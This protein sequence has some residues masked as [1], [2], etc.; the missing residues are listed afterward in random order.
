MP[1]VGIFVRERLT[2][3]DAEVVGPRSYKGRMVIRYLRLTFEALT[4]RGHFIGVEAHVLFPAG[5]IGLVA[6]RMRGIP[7]VV[8]AHGAD[9]R[10]TANENRLYRA[11]AS[12]VA[13]HADAVV[14]NSS[15][16]AEMIRSLGRDPIVNPPGI[17]LARF[18]PSPRPP[19]R[20]VLYLG[21]NRTEK[22]YDRAVG[23]ADTLAGQRLREVEP[24]EVPRLIAE[25]DI[26]LMP[27]RA[28]PY[29]L[30][31][32]EAIA[33]GRWVVAANVDGL[34]EIVTDGLNGTLVDGDEFAEAVQQVPDY[35]PEHLAATAERFSLQRHQTG[36]AR[37]WNDVVANRVAS[38]M[39]ST[40]EAVDTYGYW[41]RRLAQPG[42]TSVGRLGASARLNEALYRRFRQNVSSMIRRRPILPA[43]RAL[44][45]GTG[46]GAWVDFWHSHDVT[47]VD[48]TDFTASAVADVGGRYPGQGSVWV[49]DV[50]QADAFADVSPYPVVSCMSV[51]L[52]VIDEDRFS[53]A[54]RNLAA[55]VSP[56]GYLL[57]ADPAIVGE[58][59]RERQS[60]AARARPLRRYVDVLSASGLDLI[61]TCPAAAIAGDPVD[62]PNRFVFSV[63]GGWWKAVVLLDRLP[64]L[65]KPLAVAVEWV[66]LIA[67]RAGLS[68]T[69]KLLLFRRPI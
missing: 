29:G 26:V 20:R 4:R 50:S 14:T 56:G 47:H 2:G 30:V 36:M 21:G 7:L 19:V 42:I 23:L 43:N 22:G 53:Q 9:V 49:A 45:V 17:D 34:P 31:A 41:T 12:I 63:V 39:Q 54:L 44:D 48:A 3:V 28:E 55:L 13:R 33:S 67:Q 61:E 25:H 37:I 8:Y 58:V 24:S 18:R 11:L 32:A 52:H 38:P 65:R 6:A 51:L 68:T 1:S 15:A 69:S 5:L 62:A 60:V 16:T 66:D 57:L 27:S 46:W 40:N 64:P 35:D 10:V 59:F